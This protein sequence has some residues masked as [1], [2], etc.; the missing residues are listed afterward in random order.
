RPLDRSEP[1]LWQACCGAWSTRLN[2]RRAAASSVKR[3][4]SVPL[5][6]QKARP[7][8]T[9]SSAEMS[10]R[11]PWI[12]MARHANPCLDDATVAAGAVALLGRL[13]RDF[14]KWGTRGSAHRRRGARDALLAERPT[15]RA[16]PLRGRAHLRQE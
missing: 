3:S 12:V 13:E 7:N 5:T 8:F 1:C 2:S 4:S 11:S 14:G 16:P 6:A 15:R 10:A 9:M